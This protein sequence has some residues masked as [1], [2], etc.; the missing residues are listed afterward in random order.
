[1]GTPNFLAFSQMLWSV[2]VPKR[3][4]YTL[5]LLFAALLVVSS[6]TWMTNTLLSFLLCPR[7]F[8][9]SSFNLRIS[10][11]SL[12]HPSLMK[13]THLRAVVEF[14]MGFIYFS[15]PLFSPPK[16]SLKDYLEP[17]SVLFLPLRP[18]SSSHIARRAHEMIL[19][20]KAHL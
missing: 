14:D 19:S 3:V 8:S 4:P 2:H 13:S 5:F 18:T 16:R 20:C 10:L 12:F 15:P 6:D 7:S 9:L 17:E 1:M 11:Q